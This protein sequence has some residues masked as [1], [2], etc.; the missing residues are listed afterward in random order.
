[1]SGSLP[2]AHSA[3]VQRVIEA[4]VENRRRFEAFCRSLSDEQLDRPVP[5]ST[6]I[7]RDFIAHLDTLDP[8]MARLF[9]ATAAGE[10]IEQRDGHAF[11]VDAFNDA[12]VAERRAW[13]LD[14][15]FEEAAANRAELIAALARLSDDDI[16]KVMHFSGD[17]KRKAGQIPLNLFLAGWAQHDPIHVADMLRALPERADDAE[18]RSWLD[19]PFI[20]GYQRAMNPE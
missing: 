6:W 14:R 13:P 10:T 15:V 4:I 17:A 18:L 20:A 19:N 2:L 3:A 5:Q 12:A 9:E 11:D 7:V 16:A 1:M 8:Q